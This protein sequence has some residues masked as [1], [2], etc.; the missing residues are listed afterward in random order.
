[1]V[2]SASHCTGGSS[3]FTSNSDGTW[4]MS[5]MTSIS[6]ED[7]KKTAKEKDPLMQISSNSFLFLLREFSQSKE[8]L[9]PGCCPNLKTKWTMMQNICLEYDQDGSTNFLL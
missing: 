2:A 3:G 4:N 5:A 9:K 6:T 8:V 7:M 1:M